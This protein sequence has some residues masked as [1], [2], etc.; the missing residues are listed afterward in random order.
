[1]GSRRSEITN[2]KPKG[3]KTKSAWIKMDKASPEAKV[4]TDKLFYAEEIEELDILNSI[5]TTPSKS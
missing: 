3:S 5:S 1:M 2:P 4:V